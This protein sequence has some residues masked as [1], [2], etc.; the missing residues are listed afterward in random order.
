MR[1]APAP[2]AAA[3]GLASAVAAHLALLATACLAAACWTGA[4][5]PLPLAPGAHASDPRTP[6]PTRLVAVV[7]DRAT[8]AP[9]AGA[10]VVSSAQGRLTERYCAKPAKPAQPARPR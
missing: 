8:Q 5:P 6:C 10:T 1:R 4:T 2:A 7:H 3:L 9:L